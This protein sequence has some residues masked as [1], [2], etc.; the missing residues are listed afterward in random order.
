MDAKLLET[1]QSNVTID[2]QHLGGETEPAP[3]PELKSDLKMQQQ[4]QSI[5]GQPTSATTRA[6]KKSKKQVV[7]PQEDLLKDHAKAYKQYYAKYQK[8]YQ[9][10][11]WDL[12]GIIEELNKIK[13]K[14][15]KYNYSL[16][17]DVQN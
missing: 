2:T 4:E 16:D 3:S 14:C 15:V 12:A 1:C 5:G 9:S 8:E 11:S 7:V 17:E 13:I 6:T 10:P